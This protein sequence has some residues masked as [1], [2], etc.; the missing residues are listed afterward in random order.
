V[1][2]WGLRAQWLLE[3]EQP[4][5]QGGFCFLFL[6]SGVLRFPFPG[7]PWILDISDI[8]ADIS[9]QTAGSRFKFKYQIGVCAGEGEGSSD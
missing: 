6:G 4:Q 5:G 2:H 8:R 3:L 1:P 7:R 9:K